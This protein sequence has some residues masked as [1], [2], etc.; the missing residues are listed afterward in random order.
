MN[1]HNNTRAMVEAGI[2]TAVS[3]VLIFMCIYL[4]AFFMVGL[5]VWPIPI[6]LLYIRHGKKYSILSLVATFIITALLSDPV[7]AFGLSMVYGILGVVLGYSVT[8]KKSPAISLSIMS[9]AAL[10]STMAVFKIFSMIAGRD[11]ILQGIDTLT[12]SYKTAKSMYTAMGISKD[13]IDK[14]MATMPTPQEM[15]LI[16]PAVFIMFSI[17]VA[18]ISYIST[19]K[20]LKR[21]KHEIPPIKPVSEWFIPSKVS[22]GIL[23]IFAASFIMM[24][25]GM[26]KGSS[27][28]IN[29][30]IIFRISFSL[31][32]IALISWI[33]KKRSI[34]GFVRWVIIIFV[35]ISP[36]SQYL[37]IIGIFDYI[38]DYRKLDNS[39]RLPVK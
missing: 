21:F 13:Q 25:A 10:I 22:F 37:Y 39:R 9:V 2:M 12:A 3:V 24:A 16:I 26:S 30:N 27:Y 18:F 7:T 38:L 29:A 33:L 28:F 17:F 15:R 20:I 31:N 5:F 32:A 34:A 6:T 35:L 4:P 36:V 11:V 8:T 14:Y 23:F 1:S 19:Q